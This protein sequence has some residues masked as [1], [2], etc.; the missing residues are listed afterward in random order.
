MAVLT[1]FLQNVSHRCLTT[2]IYPSTFYTLTYSRTNV[3]IRLS[4]ILKAG[5][6]GLQTPQKILNFPQKDC[7]ERKNY[8]SEYPKTNNS[9]ICH[10]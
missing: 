2:N 4:D 10:K 3:R 8:Q 1:Q 9:A 6:A 7:R 5:V